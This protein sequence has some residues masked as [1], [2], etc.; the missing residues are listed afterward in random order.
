VKTWP[1][2]N[3]FMNSHI[4][5]ELGQRTDK[6]CSQEDECRSV[7]VEKIRNPTKEKHSGKLHIKQENEGV[8]RNETHLGL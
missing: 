5:M 4:F 6:K 1:F 2:E 7:S 3:R 8:R